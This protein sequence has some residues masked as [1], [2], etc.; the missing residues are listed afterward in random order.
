M[1]EATASYGPTRTDDAP[2]GVDEGGS[3]LLVVQGSSSSM[4]HLPRSGVV[5]L[6]RG[7][8]ADVRLRNTS[9]SREHAKVVLLD[10]RAQ[11]VDLGSRNGTLLNGVRVEGARPLGSGDVVSIGDAVVV[12]RCARPAKSRQVLDIAEL[13]RRIE[14]EIDR[15]LRHDRPAAVIAV[16]L[17]SA[18]A[19]V[20]VAGA[21]ERELAVTDF[22]GFEA[23]DR[24]LVLL[25]EAD[26]AAADDAVQRLMDVLHAVA[27]APKAGVATAPADGCDADT[28]VASARA[29]AEVAKPGQA[30]TAAEA[31]T[32]LELG[33]QRTVLAD[34]AMVRVFDLIRRLAATDLP[35]L[36]TG[37]TGSGKESAARAL[38]EWSPRA[39]RPLVT[40]NCAAVPES[41]VES[42]LFGYERGAFSGAVAS[43]PGLLE[44]GSGGTVFLDEIGDLSAS[45]QAKIL[46]AI[47]TR[48]IVRLGD[49]RE[50]EIDIRLVAA[51]HKDL[52]AEVKAGRFRQDLYYR[53][54]A[55]TVI[56]PPLR[57]RPREILALSRAFLADACARAGREEMA[58]ST[59]A[60]EL[61]TSYGWPG[62]VRELKNVV[63]YIAATVGTRIIERRHLPAALAPQGSPL[64]E[65]A[66]PAAAPA[67][68]PAGGPGRTFRPLAE[69]VRELERTRIAEALAAVGGVQTRAAEALSMP[70]RT[71]VLK[72][73]RYGLAKRRR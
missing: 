13:R 1:S 33:G 47:E 61:F 66:P 71:F 68:P 16:Q 50:R 11:L 40:L 62:N 10:G 23:D 72:M 42:E 35:V 46:R 48:R 2:R 20:A 65:S 18:S 7:P 21:L 59:E 54:G 49:V 56:L 24:L 73:N 29:A 69:E 67:A 34:A 38:H 3:Y 26:A 52:Q 41:L 15:S 8:R 32:T 28:L 12:M 60:T 63:E 58:L 64:P 22:A 45:A 53:L 36:V 19:R 55:A 44:H 70:L 4:L 9:A 37:E 30:A 6:G 39:K 43:K 25:P 51:T 31:V 57:E 14:A 27:P 17:G 5:L